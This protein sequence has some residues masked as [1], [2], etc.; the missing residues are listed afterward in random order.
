MQQ[1]RKQ[2]R[3]QKENCMNG[4][5]VLQMNTKFLSKKD[6][7]RL[8]SISE[9]A[10]ERGFLQLFGK[11]VSTFKRI[12]SQNLDKLEEQPTKDKLH[13]NDFKTALTELKAPFE[14]FFNF[15]LQKSSKEAQIFRD[16]M[17][18]DIHFIEKY[19]LERI[20]HE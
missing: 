12:F 11:E 3:K 20:L 19:M 15:E 18:R 17:I 14:N 9:G 6:F 2:A 13:E 1:L 10:F 4:F 16:I 5:I 7:L 8:N